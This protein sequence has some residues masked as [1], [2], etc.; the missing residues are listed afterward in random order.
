MS[1]PQIFLRFFYDFCMKYHDLYFNMSFPQIFE[2]LILSAFN[3]ELELTAMYFNQISI[4]FA[5]FMK[6]ILFALLQ[7]CLKM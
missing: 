2:V 3:N 6:P 1:M 4:K 7:P 5:N